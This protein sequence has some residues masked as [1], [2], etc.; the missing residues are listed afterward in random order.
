M[1]DSDNLSLEQIRAFLEGSQ[2]VAF[3]AKDRDEIYGWVE[4]T[5][6]HHNYVKL[7]RAGKGLARRYIAKMTGRSRAQVAR[8]IGVYVQEHEVKPKAYRRR[9]FPAR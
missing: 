8:L 7:G 5:L 3:Q 9:R 6:R 4:R 2:E 1:E